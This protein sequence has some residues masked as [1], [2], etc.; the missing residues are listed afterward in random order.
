MT[1]K[2]WVD[3]FTRHALTL[4]AAHKLEDDDL[5]EIAWELLEHSHVIELQP[6][7]AADVYFAI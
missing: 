1:T 7:V 5:H 4:Q 3:R 2:E 6:E